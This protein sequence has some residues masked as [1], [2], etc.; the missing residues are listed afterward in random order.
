MADILL[1][2]IA[3]FFTMAMLLIIQVCSILALGWFRD[4]QLQ[5]YA[6]E[7]VSL[8]F[9]N[10]VLKKYNPF[11]LILPCL[12]KKWQ[13]RIH[14]V[15]KRVL[16]IGQKHPLFAAIPIVLLVIFLFVRS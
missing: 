9:D 2:L 8:D 7:P 1:L 12:P 3:L 11:G 14:S 4:T 5:E 16:A 6:S 15:F 10:E 13:I